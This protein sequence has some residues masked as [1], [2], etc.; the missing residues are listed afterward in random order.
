MSHK[1]ILSLVAAGS[2]LANV[3][4]AR[5]DSCTP[6]LAKVVKSANSI[7]KDLKSSGPALRKL[8]R[9]STKLFDQQSVDTKN[10]YPKQEAARVADIRIDF[11][12]GVLTDAKA[13]L[14]YVKQ[15]HQT[16]FEQ[17][18]TFREDFAEFNCAANPKT[19]DC[20][21]IAG[22]LRVEERKFAK[23]DRTVIRH[24]ERLARIE[25]IAAP[26]LAEAQAKIDVFCL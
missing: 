22:Y 24:S 9:A 26:Q 16:S 6:L 23:L 20:R 17:L 2:I 5:A 10:L 13:R 3:S 25:S 21:N 19:Y 8:D 12:N 14:L 11:I 15:L 18:R 1:V 4:T 7:A